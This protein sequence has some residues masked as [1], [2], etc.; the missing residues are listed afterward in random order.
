MPLVSITRLRL[1][2]WRYLPP[3][4][5][6]AFRSVLQAR[7]AKGNLAVST[8]RE[9]HNTFWTRSLWADEAAMK[10]F[11]ESGAHGAVMPKL[12]EW[13]DEASVVRWTQDC[14]QEPTWKEAHRRMQRDGRASRVSHPSEA[15]R[16][17]YVAAPQVR[18]SGDPRFR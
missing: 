9:A 11:M 1:R 12:L 3:F 6:A 17:F 8:L 15:H 16:R 2:S 18:S 4:F 13:C 10:S 5:V 7:G 14:A